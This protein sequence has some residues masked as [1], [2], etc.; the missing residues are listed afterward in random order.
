MHI[1]LLVKTI[2]DQGIKQVETTKALKAEENQEPWSIKGLVPKTMKNNDIKNAI[3]QI[4]KWVG[5]TKQGDLKYKTKNYTHNF[6][7]YEKIISFF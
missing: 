6:Q 4:K 3:D 5:K 2:E 7:P 1:L